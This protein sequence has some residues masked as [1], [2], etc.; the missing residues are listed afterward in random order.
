LLQKEREQILTTEFSMLV[1]DYKKLEKLE[2]QIFSFNWSK[3]ARKLR[4]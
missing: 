2:D 3:I 1:D 4:I